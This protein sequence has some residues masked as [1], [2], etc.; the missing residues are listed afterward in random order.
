M[1][2][3][4]T[5]TRFD[6]AWILYEDAHVIAMDKPAG[7]SSQSARPESPDDARHRLAGYLAEPAAL[8]KSA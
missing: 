4:R 2:L 3:A 6:P 7:M 8:R 1:G 5:F